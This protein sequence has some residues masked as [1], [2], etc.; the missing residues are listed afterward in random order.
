MKFLQDHHLAFE[1]LEPLAAYILETQRSLLPADEE[2]QETSS[3][4]ESSIIQDHS[5]DNKAKT[6]TPPS[7]E[8]DEASAVREDSES[9]F[10]QLEEIDNSPPPPPPP[11]LII[12]DSGV[13]ADGRAVERKLATDFDAAIEAF[14][15]ATDLINEGHVQ[16]AA[17]LYDYVS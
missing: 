8:V 12:E 15:R 11:P 5:S 16:Q 3:P 6:S 7:T 1:Y 2:K 13:A 9:P 4:K 17:P 10:S 14:N